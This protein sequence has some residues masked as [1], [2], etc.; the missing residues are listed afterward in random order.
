MANENRHCSPRRVGEPYTQYL[1]RYKTWK[2]LR[3]Y[4]T[5]AV[6]RARLPTPDSNI[7]S[8]NESDIDTHRRHGPDTRLSY[9]LP[10]TSAP[11]AR[12]P[13][14]PAVKTAAEFV[15]RRPPSPLPSPTHSP[16]PLR[17]PA[18]TR[19]TPRIAARPQGAAHRSSVTGARR[20]R[21]LGRAD[22]GRIRKT[23]TRQLRSR[24][25]RLSHADVELFE[26]DN[27]SRPRPAAYTQA[28]VS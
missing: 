3:D 13:T 2:H 23:S 28:G 10:P 18:A 14:M 24:S 25:R 27:R 7:E 6:Q 22:R 1:D 12:S 21:P 26:L 4:Q 17:D 16:E 15:H 20:Q 5:R 8:E 11:G 9:H 19:P